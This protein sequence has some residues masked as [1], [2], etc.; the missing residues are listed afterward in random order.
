MDGHCEL[1]P[2]CATQWACTGPGRTAAIDLWSCQ[3]SH[4]LPKYIQILKS[5]H[6]FTTC[7]H[8][9]AMKAQALPC[10]AL[11]RS[12]LDTQQ[13]SK[14]AKKRKRW[15]INNRTIS[16]L[17]FQHQRATLST[18][19][20]DSPPPSLS[21]QA[22]KLGTGMPPNAQESLAGRKRRCILR[23]V[24]RRAKTTSLLSR[25]CLAKL[26]RSGQQLLSDRTARVCSLSHRR[27]VP[28]RA[29]A[30]RLALGVL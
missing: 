9:G 7:R 22:G 16:S 6:E 13:A 12:K 20:S 23:L 28:S 11:Q 10:P 4:Q 26:L 2:T 17:Q 1:R 8:H 15:D 27:I 18:S 29:G 19:T 25:L 5:Q 30:L 21:V 24:G 3:A 14:Q